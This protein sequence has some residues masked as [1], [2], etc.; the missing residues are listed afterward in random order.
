MTIRLL[1]FAVSTTAL[2]L[3]GSVVGSPTAG[4]AAVA[5]I[6]SPA[7]PRGASRTGGSPGTDWRLLRS[8]NFSAA[9]S[10]A[11]RRWVPSDDGKGT[12]YDV[13]GYDDDGAYFDAMG[14]A[15][16]RRQ[17]GTFQTLRK[18]F[19]LGSDGWLTA[20]MS[21]RDGNLDG[22]PDRP[23]RLRTERVAGNPSLLI[24]E[25]SHHGG[26]VIRSTEALPARYRVEVRLRTIDFGGE[27][28][29]SWDYPDGRINGYS[30]T[31][32]TTNH[33][34]AHDGSVFA[35]RPCR[36]RNVRTD[37]NGFYY[38]SVMDYP[39]PAPHNNVFIHTHR[40]VV[41]DGYNRYKWTRDMLYCNPATKKYEPYYEGTGNGVN[42][43][44]PT[45]G[46]QNPVS[47]GTAYVIETE[48]GTT[49]GPVVSAADLRPELLPDRPYRFAVERD[50]SGYTLETS[51]VFAH[52]GRATLRYHRDFVEDGVP[53]WHY[54]QTAEEYDGS[55][56]R[57]WSY[58]GDHGT[59]TD[60]D[61]W[62]AGSAYPDYFM[63][64][65]P[66][67]NYYEGRAHI[68]DIKLFVPAVDGVGDAGLERWR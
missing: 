9:V 32:C 19:R 49:K 3:L 57:D 67:T 4:S 2:T 48:C 22:R 51:G 10:D 39:R 43:I 37:S 26:V 25:P 16:F 66:H 64:G 62:P 6:D 8:T 15:A 40:K 68:D 20:E 35:K 63:I 18:R 60:R 50:A 33:P 5:R 27:R 44:F 24:D 14:G 1:A 42:M 56:N 59:F 36:W 17:L 34:W 53:I 45:A 54:N 65:D 61:V 46:R 31:G 11:G 30:P 55:F 12:R 38:L 13:D 29:G 47:P 21:A 7:D 58:T 52:V 28:D 23:P 41:I